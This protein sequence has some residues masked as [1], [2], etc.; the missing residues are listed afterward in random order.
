[1][2]VIPVARAV[3]CPLRST[4]AIASLSLD[5]T[6]VTGASFADTTTTARTLIVSPIASEVDTGRTVI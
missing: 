3:T 4:L 5:Q 6:T 2:P 1:M